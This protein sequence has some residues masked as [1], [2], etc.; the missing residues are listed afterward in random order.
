MSGSTLLAIIL[1]MVI[2]WFVSEFVFAGVHC[3]S[4]IGGSR[5]PMCS[6][7]LKVICLLV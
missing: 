2:L 3:I 6:P 7:L 5:H 1:S 4:S